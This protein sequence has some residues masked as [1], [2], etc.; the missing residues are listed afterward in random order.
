LWGPG[1]YAERI[2]ISHEMLAL[3]AGDEHR[4]YAS[5]QLA[6]ALH[7]SGR[8]AEADWWMARCS[9]VGGRLRHTSADVPM[10]WWHWMRAVE[11]G[12]PRA[13]E[14]AE[15][16]SAMHRRSSVVALV[17]VVGLVTVRM[18]P[19]Q[20]VAPDVVA[21]AREHA[22]PGY[23]ATIAHALAEY[24]RVD[25]AVELLGAPNADVGSDYAALAGCCMRVD[26]LAHAGRVDL[27]PSALAQITPFADEVV[28]YGT[29]DALGSVEYFI[30]R[31]L[32]ALGD[33]EG[34]AKRFARAVARNAELGNVP[35]GRRAAERLAEVSGEGG[36]PDRS[37][38]GLAAR[39]SERA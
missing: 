24:G 30:G 23:R 15:A 14:L 36:A 20:D 10:A 22:N 29:I 16:G 31:G 11:Q 13:K 9:E 26:V 21:G 2:A 19:G 17:E 27:L 35:W 1:S 3:T 38:A 4:L 32:Q 7:Q 18:A 39:T 5:W 34:A 33:I 25:E 8:P 37:Q 28:T 6:V 12:D